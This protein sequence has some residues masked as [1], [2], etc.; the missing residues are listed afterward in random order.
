MVFETQRFEGAEPP[1]KPQD[2]GGY[3]E[4]ILP[5]GAVLQKRYEIIK[6]LFL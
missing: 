6:V 5:K 4:N 1:K 3:D 2:T